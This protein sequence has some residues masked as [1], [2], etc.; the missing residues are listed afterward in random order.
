RSRPGQRIPGSRSIGEPRTP[1][2]FPVPVP[3]NARPAQ[4]S[5]SV[6]RGPS[7]SDHPRRHP[8]RSRASVRGHP[9][10]PMLI[11][12]P[13]AFLAGGLAADLAGWALDHPDGA[14][15]GYYLVIAGI[16]TGI[17]AAFAGLIDYVATVPPNSSARRRATRHMVVNLAALFLFAIAWYLRGGPGVQPEPVLLV[18]EA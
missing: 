7:P 3:A 12:F 17:V 9:I 11:P 2:S 1:G 16:A 18:I 10:H 13:I 14:V 8:M 4:E 15:I 6:L 5:C